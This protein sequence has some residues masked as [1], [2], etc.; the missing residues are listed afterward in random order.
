M[1]QHAIQE[2]GESKHGLIHENDDGDV[3]YS[4]DR[5]HEAE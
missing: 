1:N 5:L 2:D 3:A 4:G